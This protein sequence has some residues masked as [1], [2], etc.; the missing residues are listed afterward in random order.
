MFQYSTLKQQHGMKWT[1]SDNINMQTGS[2]KS[3]RKRPFSGWF[4]QIKFEI[5]PQIYLYLNK[6]QIQMIS[7]TG[8]VQIAADTWLAPP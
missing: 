7:I 1:L 4:T 8:L 6:S 5:L 2:W 3:L